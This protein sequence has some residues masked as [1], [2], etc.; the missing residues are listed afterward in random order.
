M[1][2]Y[3]IRAGFPHMYLERT[4]GNSCPPTPFAVH[5]SLL[6]T[7]LWFGEV[8]DRFL[9]RRFPLVNYGKQLRMVTSALNETCGSSRASNLEWNPRRACRAHYMN[10]SES[11]ISPSTFLKGD[12][13][14][15]IRCGVSGNM[16]RPADGGGIR[17]LG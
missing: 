4:A 5:S 9:R 10:S 3:S 11:I 6:S 8:Q 15:Q 13:A 1:I 2:L 14:A 7:F 16:V 17:R 12:S